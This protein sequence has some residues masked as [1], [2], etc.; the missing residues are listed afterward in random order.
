MQ[1]GNADTLN[2]AVNVEVNRIAGLKRKFDEEAM[3]PLRAANEQAEQ[4]VLEAKA[5]RDA[6]YN[7]VWKMQEHFNKKHMVH[8]QDEVLLE[9]LKHLLRIHASATSSYFFDTPQMQ[10]TGM[11]HSCHP[12]WT[13]FLK[14]LGIVK[15]QIMVRVEFEAITDDIPDNDGYYESADWNV[16][17]VSLLTPGAVKWECIDA[18]DFII[19]SIGGVPVFSSCYTPSLQDFDDCARR[20]A[21]LCTLVGRLGHFASIPIDAY[22]IK[23]DMISLSAIQAKISEIQARRS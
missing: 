8:L 11:T 17:T 1:S 3:M 10:K 22:L 7:R 13:S 23:P 6:A 18:P 15:D 16:V 19:H 21:E 9:L 5:R 2:K 20:S 4:E 14:T 12:V